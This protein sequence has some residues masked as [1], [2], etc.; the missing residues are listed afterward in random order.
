MMNQAWKPLMAI[1]FCGNLYGATV[2][3][4][5]A[6]ATFKQYCTGCHGKAAT[7]GINLEQL[8][9]SP[10]TNSSFAQWQKVAA[11]LE[12]KRM[13]PARAPQPSDAARAAAA[14]WVH[15]SLKNF[16]GKHAGD[17]GGVTVR[18]LT[19]AEYG[20]T[21][22]DL[23]GLDPD[24]N[25]EF[26]GDAVGGE[27]FANFGDV[28]FISDANL[29]R[30]MESAKKI[31]DHAVIGSGPLEFSEHPGKTGFELAAINRIK[32]IYTVYGF[33]TV[34]GEGGFPFGLDK[35]T[36]VL[37]VAWEYKHRA[38]LGHPNAQLAELAA[39]ENITARFA[40]HIWNVLQRTNLGYPSSEVATRWRKLPG[41][42]SDL[43]A[44]ETAA[45]ANCDEIQKFLTGWPGWLF[46]RGDVASGGQGDESPLII[47]D[48]TLAGEPVHHFNYP[49]GFR[50]PGGATERAAAPTGPLKVFMKV[51]AVDPNAAAKPI[52][53]W[54]NARVGTRTFGPRSN[55]T[56]AGDP[57]AVAAAAARNIRVTNV[58]PLREMLS[59]E[60]V[61][62]LNFGHSPDG[63]E[64]GPDDFATVGEGRFELPQQPQGTGPL[65]FQVDAEIG[66][67]R[68]TVVRIIFSSR[69]D[70]RVPGIPTRAL[71]SDPTSKGYQAF[72]A[73][74]LEMVK[75]LP[76]NA[77][78]EPTPAD[79]DP[80][81]LPFDSTYNTPEHDEWVARIKYTRD[82]RYIYEN[83]LD[84]TT[85]VKLD[86]AWTNL[87]ASFEYYDNYLDLFDKKFKLGLKAKHMSEL[88]PQ[89]LASMPAEPR[90]YLAPLRAE[91]E[92]VQ[93][94]QL[95]ARPGH[96][97]D[98]LRFASLAW[99]RPL[100]DAEKQDLRAFYVKAKAGPEMDHDKA[101]RA[102]ITRILVSPAFLYRVERP[103]EANARPLTSWEMASRLS[104]FL[105]SSMPDAELRRAAAAGELAN[106]AQ[107]ERQVKRMMAD[108]KARRFAT[109]FFGQWLGFYRFDQFKGVD[110]T[111]FPEFT[112]DV[113]S[114]MY[115]EAILFFDYLIRKDRPVSEILT[116]DYTFLN[117]PLASHYGVKKEMKSP[118]EFELVQDANAYHRGGILRMGAVLTATSAPLRTS[119]VKR[120]DWVLRRLLG[121]PTPP[122]PADAGSIPA[123]DKLFAGLSLRQKLESHKRNATCASCHTRIDPLGFPLEH[124]DPTGRW[125]AQYADGKA[126]DDTSTTKDGVDVAGAEGL[127]KYLEK[128]QPQVM[129]NLS[130][131]MIG[132]ALGRTVLPSDEPLI[133]KL[134][135]EGNNATVEKLVSQIVDSKQFR[136]RRDKDDE[137]PAVPPQQKAAVQAG[138]KATNGGGF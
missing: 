62:K 47:S 57:A 92:A 15:A 51:N 119:P 55:V 10:M 127:Q 13:P 61:A 43:K 106:P 12:E 29:E 131:K 99:R 97:E 19:S 134:M 16:A 128:Q 26:A 37:Y 122:P 54:R 85:R 28:Q 121:T 101:V 17:P 56:A 5:D 6:A 86:Q 105:W 49:L 82:D 18:R 33:R 114:A 40:Q 88:T 36:R 91:Y 34:S 130:R 9:V 48:A 65:V 111:R 124:F 115:D 102:L 78:G 8:S 32:D 53:I 66:K 129:R 133:E 38:A 50:R 7:A 95:G 31:A 81:P 75:L 41:P 45:R 107:L 77:Y 27:G 112:Q 11:V 93:K 46:A 72:K 120:G 44:S 23:T 3:T 136:Y 100:T 89:D 79:K 69:D 20:Y 90:K 125:R 71:L 73:G 117:K 74:V 68:D 137:S 30:Y 14:T 76:P 21:I 39:K 110:T 84:D 132:Y 94:A 83:I 4:P 63:S 52:V 138:R 118:T 103:A 70:G 67:N 80:A 60:W 108:E 96:V 24:F 98:C 87:Y 35:Y 42:S 104:Y 135:A 126:I 116:A 22:H 59:P 1:V 113:K 64:M 2:G 123:D 109:E 25:S 58:K